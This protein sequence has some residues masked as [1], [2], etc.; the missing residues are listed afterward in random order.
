[1]RTCTGCV[2][3]HPRSHSRASPSEAERR[4]GS[5]SKGGGPDDEEVREGG[6]GL[7]L[8]PSASRRSRA[9]CRNSQPMC[10]WQ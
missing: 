2:F 3:E 6:E 10:P 8:T 7:S 4:S 5:G 9:S 1:M